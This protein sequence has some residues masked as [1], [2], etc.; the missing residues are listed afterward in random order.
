MVQCNHVPPPVVLLLPLLPEIA[1]AKKACGPIATQQSKRLAHLYADQ[2][3]EA[4]CKL[5]AMPG[6]EFRINWPHSLRQARR[7]QVPAAAP[8]AQMQET[9]RYIACS[10]Q[11]GVG[12]PIRSRREAH[13]GGA[14]VRS[15]QMLLQPEHAAVRSYLRFPQIF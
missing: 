8:A 9:L 5:D 4:V 11:P 15:V 13:K 1:H 2:Q 7:V 10:T 12:L 3:R 14:D 6:C